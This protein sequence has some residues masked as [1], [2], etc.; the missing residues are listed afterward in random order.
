MVFIGLNKKT[1]VSGVLC[2]LVLRTPGK[3]EVKVQ[4]QDL[5]VAVDLPFLAR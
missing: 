4:A 3:T 5:M 2:C 1:V